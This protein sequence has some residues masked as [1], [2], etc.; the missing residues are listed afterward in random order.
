MYSGQSK[1]V[2]DLCMVSSCD[3]AEKFGSW[4]IPLIVNLPLAP[5]PPSTQRPS[6]GS[7]ILLR[8][9]YLNSSTKGSVAYQCSVTKDRRR[10]KVR[11]H[12]HS[13]R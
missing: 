11:L 13:Q 9:S 7:Q 10:A 2:K 1:G 12:L 5:I 4:E 6:L 8:L 3:F